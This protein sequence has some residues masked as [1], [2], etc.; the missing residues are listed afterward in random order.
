MSNR[1]V[2]VDNNTWN[3]THIATVGKFLASNEED[4]YEIAQSLDVNYALVVFGGLSAYG[5]DDL[6]KFLWF[7]RIAAG[8]FPDV[9]EQEYYG[10]NGFGVAAEQLSEK[11]KNSMTY[12]MM[13]YRFGEMYTVAD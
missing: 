1:T 12:K 11:F 8:E 2:I 3:N 9:H 10:Q 4:G 7:V 13:Y 6:I 5:S